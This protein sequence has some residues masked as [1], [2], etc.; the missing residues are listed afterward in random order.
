MRVYL[1]LP[2]SAQCITC[3][4]V[5]CTHK[6]TFLIHTVILNQAL[7]CAILC[8]DSFG[9]PS[10]NHF[11]LWL[12][13]IR[14]YIEING[15]VDTTMYINTFFCSLSWCFFLYCSIRYVSFACPCLSLRT[16]ESRFLPF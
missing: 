3:T 6:H 15:I 13:Y 10:H 9:W 1:I 11:Y 4:R 16:I 5:R 12:A 2:S 14:I 7:G 8:I